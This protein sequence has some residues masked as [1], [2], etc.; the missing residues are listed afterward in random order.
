MSNRAAPNLRPRLFFSAIFKVRGLLMAPLVAVMAFSVFWEYKRDAVNLAIGL[1]L[2]A[3]GWAVRVWS[4]C[5]LKYRVRLATPQLSTDGPYRWIRNPVYVGNTLML[6]ALA[7]LCELYWMLPI[8][9]GWALLVYHLSVVGFEEIRLAK[10]FGPSYEQYRAAVP[11]WVPSL[12]LTPLARAPQRL[13]VGR[14][15]LVEWQCA[16]L[17]LV[18][19]IKEVVL[20]PLR[21]SQ[22]G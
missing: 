6:A 11:R 20:D 1:P 13:A 3:L 12:P 9:I 10:M 15:I 17:L 22:P 21:H 18:P 16:L 2:F 14:A 7:V 5:H 19:L 4:Q 8:T